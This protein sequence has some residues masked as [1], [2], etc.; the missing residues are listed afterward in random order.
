[1][2]ADDVGGGGID[3]F[4]IGA[5]GT[6]TPLSGSPF[7]MPGGW[8]LYLVDRLAIDPSGKFLYVPDVT[9]NSIVGFAIDS[10][11][12]ALT[13]IASSPFS[14]IDPEELLIE[15]S[16]KFL[17]ASLGGGGIG[18]FTIDTST[19]TLTPILGSPFGGNL[20]DGLASDP[21]G[22]F[23]F[24]AIP[25][26]SVI[27]GFT[28]SQT[29]GALTP[30]AG[31][32]Y[33]PGL[34]QAFPVLYSL[35]V[36]PSGDFLYALDSEYGKVYGYSVDGASGGLTPLASSPL[37]FS[38]ATYMSTIEVE[39]SGKFLYIGDQTANLTIM[40]IDQSS[41]ALAL[42]PLTTSPYSPSMTIVRIP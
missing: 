20:P 2:Y 3:G 12:G 24:A 7:P 36:T 26:Y 29:T 15:A 16:G 19:G 22:K 30:V 38:Y 34:G 23:L 10:A 5:S 9:T 28:I 4:S 32:P 41:G 11:T 33:F 21:A 25:A 13:P 37:T 18:A 40:S 14:A 27:E 31:S 6:L 1:L 42:L 8:S 35:T 17:Y 39:P